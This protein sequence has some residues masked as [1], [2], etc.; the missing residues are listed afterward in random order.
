MGFRSELVSAKGNISL[1]KEGE[2]RKKALL[3]LLADLGDVPEVDTHFSLLLKG[4]SV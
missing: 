4:T 2:V 3:N 1:E